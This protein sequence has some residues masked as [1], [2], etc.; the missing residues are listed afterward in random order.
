[1]LVLI[2]SSSIVCFCGEKCFGDNTLQG[3]IS[4]DSKEDNVG[5][6]MEKPKLAYPTMTFHPR[7]KWPQMNP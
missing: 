2:V 1:V 7:V 5:T 4:N 3:K 6:I